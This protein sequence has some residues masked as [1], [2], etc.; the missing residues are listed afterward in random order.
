[1]CEYDFCVNMNNGGMCIMSGDTQT[2]TQTHKH[3][4]RHTH[5]YQD[6][7]MS[8]NIQLF[9]NKIHPII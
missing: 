8:E 3:T 6:H 2:D 5:Q 4:H 1:M 9:D 7:T